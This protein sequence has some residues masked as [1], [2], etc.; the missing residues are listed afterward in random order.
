MK[1]TLLISI[2][3]ILVALLSLSGELRSQDRWSLEDCLKYARE[4]NLSIE[5]AT[6]NHSVAVTDRAEAFQTRLPNLTSS[7]GYSYSFGRNVDPTTNDFVPQNLGFSSINLNTNVLLYNGGRLRNQ[8]SQALLLEK[9]ADALRKQTIQ[10]VELEI[11]LAFLTILFERERTRNAEEQL[12]ASN[13]QLDRIRQLIEV[14]MVP[15]SDQFEW[16]AQAAADEQQIMISENAVENAIFQLKS[17][18]NLDPA[19][20]FEVEI[21][22]VDPDTDLDDYN[23]LSV[24]DQVK[25]TRPEIL[26]MDF[27]ERAAEKGVALAESARMPS[28]FFGAGLNTNYSTLS[29][30]L[31]D[32]TL[33]RVPSDGVFING[34]SVLF[35]Q[36]TSVP[37]SAFRTPFFE[38]LNQNL[39]FALGVQLNIPI[40]D[41]G[42]FKA[43]VDRAKHNLSL[44]RN[45]NRQNQRA[46]ELQIQEI[47][48]DLKT[49]EAQYDAGLRRVEYLQNAYDNMNQRFGLGMSNNYDL[50]DAQ[51]RLNQAVSEATIAKFN[52]LFRK[53]VLDF[54]LGEPMTLD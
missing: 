18:L 38:Q 19:G 16:I 36:E 49:A 2:T 51:V 30:T 20:P 10:D 40:Y 17:I 27:G 54:Y 28:L 4:N 22:T 23:F 5:A 26:A 39:G 44:V 29:Q 9:E 33:R 6:I 37:L 7:S 35:E 12:T 31:E 13:N 15:E 41:R 11:A 48:A 32:F 52:L 45:Q 21:P 14:E 25:R 43:D 50:L 47:L 34:E 3:F 46:L 8:Y 53:K 42:R 1:R 24:L